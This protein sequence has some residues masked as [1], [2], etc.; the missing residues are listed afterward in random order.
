[1]KVSAARPVCHTGNNTCFN[2]TA[3]ENELQKLFATIV[4]RKEKLPPN[5]YTTSLFKAGADK[6]SLKVAEESL[7]VIHAAQKET[8]KPLVEE[9]VDLVYHLWVLLVDKDVSLE[10]IQAEVEK[11]N[12]KPDG[13]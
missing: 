1:M 7:E 6:I 3:D 8:K 5:S 4:S 10:Q 9:A 11:R 13:R 12:K 2:E